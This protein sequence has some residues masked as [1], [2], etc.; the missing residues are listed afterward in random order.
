MH[1][2]SEKVIT[3]ASKFDW[4]RHRQHAR[5]FVTVAI[6]RGESGG[7]TAQPYKKS[8]HWK[9]LSAKIC[10]LP[11]YWSEKAKAIVRSC[12][13]LLAQFSQM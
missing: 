1:H 10:I 12:N 9:D 4:Q 3:V 11:Q 5:T 8:T 13:I 7:K 6:G 2:L